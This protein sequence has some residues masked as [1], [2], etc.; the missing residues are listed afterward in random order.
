MTT[1]M[2]DLFELARRYEVK[3]VIESDET[4]PG[5]ILALHKDQYCAKCFIPYDYPD[6]ADMRL[7][8][9]S[10]PRELFN[11]A[12]TRLLIDCNAEV[13]NEYRMNNMKGLTT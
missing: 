11:D 8:V 7:G 9:T 5:V 13:I 4:R 12:L 3:I 6:W 2:S 1:S 10:T